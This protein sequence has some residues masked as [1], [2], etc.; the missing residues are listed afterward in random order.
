[1]ELQSTSRTDDRTVRN[2]AAKPDPLL[3]ESTLRNFAAKYIWWESPEEALQFPDRV[4]AQVMDLG[5]L[6]DSGELLSVCGAPRLSDV[7]RHAQAGWFSPRSWH[8]WHYRLRLAAVG[9]VPTLPVRK[10]S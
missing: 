7:I 8:Y 2:D 3:Q 6:E 5:T 4:I 1:M 9:Q 10:F